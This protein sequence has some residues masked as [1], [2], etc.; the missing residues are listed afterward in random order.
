MDETEYDSS[1]TEYQD[2]RS[3]LRK[4]IRKFYLYNIVRLNKGKA[5]DFGC[6]IGELLIL[7]P[8]DSLGLEINNASVAYCRNRNLNVILYS[9]KED[10]YK[11]T[12]LEKD[13]Y[14]TFIMSHVLEHMEKPKDVLL[15]VMDACKRLGIE[16]I[17]LV[18]PGYKGFLSDKTHKIF[19]NAKYMTSNNLED[20][21]HFTL[22][23]LKYFPFNSSQIGE[24]ITHNETVLVYDVK[25]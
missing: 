6:G 9:P 19:I 3:F 25:E 17:I 1:Y 18:V 24:K 4:F 14:G 21:K 16:R 7:L 12:N 23:S 10:N 11:F 15:K 20:T 5:I 8:K 13:K 2:K 22:T